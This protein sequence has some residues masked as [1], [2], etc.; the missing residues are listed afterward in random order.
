[1]GVWRLEVSGRIGHDWELDV[2][3]DPTL[4]EY[5]LRPLAAKAIE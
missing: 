1:M 2:V 4:V 3:P 5:W